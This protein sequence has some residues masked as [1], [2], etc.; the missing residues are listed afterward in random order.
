MLFRSTSADD[1]HIS[2]IVGAKIIDENGK[3]RGVVVDVLS[4]PAQDT[5]VINY[6]DREVLV[7]FV[8]S[9]VPIIDIDKREIHVNNFEGL[10]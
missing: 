1:F 7:P 3:D 8:K 10:L 4:L 9:Y 5:L 6:E 2:Q